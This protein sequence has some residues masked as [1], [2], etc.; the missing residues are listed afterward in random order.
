MSGIY[1]VV[2]KNTIS[3]A[4][5]KGLEIW[6]DNYG[7]QQRQ[8][9][10]NGSVFLGIKPE[11]IKVTSDEEKVFR[12]KEYVGIFDALIFSEVTSGRSDERFLFDNICKDGIESAKSVNGDF[13][14]AI[15]NDSKK[16]LLLLRD[17]LG[18][19]PLFYYAD[20][21]RVIFS[22]DIRGILS[23]KDVDAAVNEEWLY[24]Y[25]F[26]GN[27]QI[28]LRTEYEHI[29]CV[30][31]GGWVRFS[32]D[33]SNIAV[34][35]GHYY[36]PGAKK[37]RMKDR[38]AYTKELRRRVTEAVKVRAEVTESPVGAE[39]SGGLD[40]GVISLVLANIGKKCVYYSWSPSEDKL[41]LAESD[42]RLVVKDICEK[43]GIIC[44]YGGLSV[45][46]DTPL[47]KE[48]FPLTMNGYEDLPY[49]IGC[50][51]PPY[52]NTP[53]IFETASF[54][55]E[56]GV[57]FIFSGHGGD[58]GISHR[59]N[60]YELFHYHE[61]YRYFR[62]M[63]SRS[64]I[65]KHRISKT[66]S[67]IRDNF[68]TANNVLKTPFYAEHVA[69]AVFNSEFMSKHR[70]TKV[71]PLAFAYDPIEYVIEGG[72]QNRLDVLAFY[73]SCT[74][75]RYLIPYL[76]YNVMDFALGIPRYLYHDWYINRFIFREAFKDLM[77]D[78]LYRQRTKES[79]SYANLPKTDMSEYEKNRVSEA[80]I[81][82]R[83][84]YL[85][86]LDKSYW[87]KYLDYGILED[88][89]Y[90]RNKVEDDSRLD[91]AIMTCM[92]VEHLVKRAREAND[93]YQAEDLIANTQ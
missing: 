71:K 5:Y 16:E 37:I 28:G 63:Y 60:P 86:H 61:Y 42:E 44:N 32:F 17:H 89:V 65:S 58:E 80:S 43:A 31:F 83:K 4:D 7:D 23:V 76:D 33:G 46:L 72:S 79:A 91:R 14:G 21:N 77:P 18:V 62:L 53:P 2:S 12:E 45:K 3:I 67:L 35:E 70:K 20:N 6:N 8:C 47:M 13:S 90:G 51:F 54:M 49:V 68:K 75:V 84:K 15:W 1:G 48:H 55:K 9:Y 19:R 24:S 81:E 34:E 25:L 52:V 38:A 39:L 66:I 73:S 22:T 10:A 29:R 92:Q 69:A 87:G 64:S 27:S 26:M 93:L 74:G 82:R 11:Q 30:P 59:S 78:S 40:S 36:V 88:W 56:R 50:A 41:A 85:D 57:K